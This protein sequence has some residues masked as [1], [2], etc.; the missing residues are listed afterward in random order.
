ML[1]DPVLPW[2]LTLAFSVTA[3]YTAIRLVLDRK[4]L[5]SIAH[6]LHLVMSLAMIAMCWPWWTVVPARPQLLLFAAGTAWFAALTVLQARFRLARAALGDHGAWHQVAHAV[7]MLAMVWMLL[8]MPSGSEAGAHTHHHGGLD[9]WPALTGV[10]I[11]AS[12]LTSG[13][14]FLVELIRC[15]R[16]RRTWRGHAGDVA[17]G[18]VMSLGMAAMCWP[19][20]SG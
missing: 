3:A 1:S 19:M 9:L 8:A 16:G 10:V 14:A 6:A 12:L 5:L 11:T 2:V 20:I 15:R 18:A 7:M 17:S 4:P 13:V